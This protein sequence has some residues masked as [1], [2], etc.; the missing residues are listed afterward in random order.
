MAFSYS[1]HFSEL[2]FPSYEQVFLKAELLEE[3]RL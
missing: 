2:I 3:R 1:Y